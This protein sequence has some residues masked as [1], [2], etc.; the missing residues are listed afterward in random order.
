MLFIQ[1]HIQQIVLSFKYVQ[2]A[3]NKASL[4]SQFRENTGMTP[5]YAIHYMTTV[6]TSV[7]EVPQML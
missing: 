7:I 4:V 6:V 3:V 2:G 5:S 1:S